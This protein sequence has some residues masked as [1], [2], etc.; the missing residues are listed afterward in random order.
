[1]NRPYLL[2]EEPRGEARVGAVINFKPHVTP[3]QAQKV[4]EG[5]A[6][7]GYIQPTYAHEYDD[8]YGGPVWYIP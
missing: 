8:Y 7:A 3:M 6:M 1:M 5:L 2:D 4:L